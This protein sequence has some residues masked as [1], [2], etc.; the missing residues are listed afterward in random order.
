[1]KIKVETVLKGIKQVDK[2]NFSEGERSVVFIG[3][4]ERFLLLILGYSKK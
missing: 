2:F 1:M 3:E 4:Q